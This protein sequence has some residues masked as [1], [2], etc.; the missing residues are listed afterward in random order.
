M[1]GSTPSSMFA[2]RALMKD[3]PFVI[4]SLIF[5]YSVCI[6]AY[7]LRIFEL[8]LTK[9]SG[10]DFENYWNSIWNVVITMTTVG[11]NFLSNLL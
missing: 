10:Q 7:A 2:I 8:P 9:V 11:K 5:T 6:M 3:Q 1:V 4:L